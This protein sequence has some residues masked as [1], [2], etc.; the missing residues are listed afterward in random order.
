MMSIWVECAKTSSTFPS[1]AL[2]HE[3]L[4][5]GLLLAVLTLGPRWHSHRSEPEP[6]SS[7]EVILGP[8][9]GSPLRLPLA[10]LLQFLT[11]LLHVV[12]ILCVFTTQMGWEHVAGRL[13]EG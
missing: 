10:H 4:S 1:P 11:S 12:I 6:V 5:D 2:A 13:S 9:S 8:F 3:G 7:V